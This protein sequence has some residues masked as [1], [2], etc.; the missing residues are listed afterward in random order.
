MWGSAFMVSSFE[1]VMPRGCFCDR[2]RAYL[3]PVFGKK[4][5]KRLKCA[6]RTE[7][8]TGEGRGESVPKHRGP[9]QVGIPGVGRN[10][11]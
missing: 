7:K 4:H 6:C 1:V 10:R 8:D 11:R 3:F 5:M 9:T 2:S